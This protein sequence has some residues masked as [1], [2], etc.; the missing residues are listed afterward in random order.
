MN[1]DHPRLKVTLF[2]DAAFNR[3]DAGFGYAFKSSICE[4]RGSKKAQREYLD[5]DHAELAGISWGLQMAATAHPRMKAQKDWLVL[6]DNVNA[7]GALRLIG[8]RTVDKDSIIPWRDPRPCEEYILNWIERF[9]MV[10]G[11]RLLVRHVPG[12]QTGGNI[13]AHMN[14]MTDRL[15]KAG[16]HHQQK[17]VVIPRI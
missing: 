9:I 12:H 10:P 16:R 7:L 6:C 17:A 1:F 11:T 13:H 3:G 8:A 4:G 14:R 5:S 15:A 2:S